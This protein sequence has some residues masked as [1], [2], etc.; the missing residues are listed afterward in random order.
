MNINSTNIKHI[1][2]K[3]AFGER[4]D[5]TEEYGIY[6]LADDGRW[7]LIK[8]VKQGDVIRLKPEA[9]KTYVRSHYIREDAYNRYCCTDWDGGSDKYLKPNTKVWIDF[10]F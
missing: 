1:I 7:E 3:D 4:V 9:T 5:M 8:N 6:D 10:I 2:R